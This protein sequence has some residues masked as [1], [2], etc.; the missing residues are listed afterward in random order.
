[1]VFERGE[2]TAWQRLADDR[3]C[4]NKVGVLY[5]FYFFYFFPELKSP[6]FC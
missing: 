3:V 6:K 5:F 4:Y 2:L 1:M